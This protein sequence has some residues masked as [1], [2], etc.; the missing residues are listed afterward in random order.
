MLLIRSI[1]PA[2]SLESITILLHRAYARLGAMGLNYTAVDQTPAMTSER[3]NG[4]H[5]FVAHWDGQLAGTVLVKPPDPTSECEYFVRD[6]VASL[7]QF[8]VDPDLQGRGI[9][10]ALVEACENWACQSGHREL[11]LDT[12][13]PAIHLVNLYQGMGFAHVGFVQWPGKSYRSVVMSK[14]LR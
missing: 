3:M 5:C 11:A 8:A 1:E 12:A 7:R 13:E 6:S 2:D 14:S 10:H 4:G 9:G